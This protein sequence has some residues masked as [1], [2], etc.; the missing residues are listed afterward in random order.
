MATLKLTMAC[1]EYDRTRPLLDGTVKPEGVELS[2]LVLGWE[3]M[4]YRMGRFR[5]FDVS[6]FSLSSYTA[7]RSRDE[8]L[9]AIPVFPSRM[10]RHS[11]IYVHTGAGIQSPQDLRGKRAGVPKFHMTAAVWIRG[12]LQDEYGVKPQDLLWYEGGEGTLVKEVDH[13]LP[14][15][16]RKE[17]VPAGKVLGDMV[18]AGEL[19]AFVGARMP[20]AFAAGSP[21]IRRLFPNYREAEKAYFTKTGLFPIMHTVVIRRDLV[22]QHPWLPAS[23]YNAFCRAKEIALQRMAEAAALTHTLPWLLAELE[24]TK[25][26]MGADPWPY[27]VTA[28]RKTLET[29]TRYAFDEGLAARRLRAEDMFPEN[30]HQT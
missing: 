18:A 26:L 29:L 27:G 20:K 4:F 11:C 10:F 23:L 30:L 7:L 3:E 13:A 8:D 28:N 22:R 19:D 15:S 6:E 21:G 17:Q 14:P 12:M 25:A 1:G 24:E 9:V 5:E 16:I 2:C